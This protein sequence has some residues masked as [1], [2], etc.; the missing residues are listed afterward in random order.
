MRPILVSFGILA[1][2][3]GSVVQ[4]QAC[5]ANSCALA[6]TGTD[7]PNIM[8]HLANCSSFMLMTVTPMR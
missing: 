2:A 8:S 4:K 7:T 3:L 5:M 6:M 1:P